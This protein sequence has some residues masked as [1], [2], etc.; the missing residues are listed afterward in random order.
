MVGPQADGARASKRAD[1]PAAVVRV[2]GALGDNENWR[3]CDMIPH[4][5]PLISRERGVCGPFAVAV[6]EFHAHS[7]GSVQG[8]SA[9]LCGARTGRD[10]NRGLFVRRRAAPRRSGTGSREKRDLNWMSHTRCFL[11]AARS[12]L[13]AS[14]FSLLARPSP[15]PVLRANTRKQRHTRESL[16]RPP[17]PLSGFARAHSHLSATPAGPN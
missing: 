3:A 15:A 9:R 13:F 8:R 14:R 4:C 6:V 12:R 7:A 16:A 11:C 1:T 17:R 10:G 2:A 5:H